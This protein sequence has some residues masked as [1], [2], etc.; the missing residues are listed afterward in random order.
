MQIDWS[1]F[2]WVLR[3]TLT[4]SLLSAFLGTA[5]GFLV[6][7][8]LLHIQNQ[9]IKKWVSA[10][11][12]AP[13]Y[14]PTLFFVLALLQLWNGF[15]KNIAGVIAVHI[16]M[17]FGF[18][19]LLLH[20]GLVNKAGPS[21]DLAIVLGAKKWS[22]IR[23]VLLPL[24]R[25]DLLVSFAS[26]FLFS[27][28]SFSVPML[29]GGQQVSSFEVMIYE[30][31]RYQADWSAA[32][33]I[34]LAQSVFLGA[35]FILILKPQREERKTVF[36]SLEW[37][38]LPYTWWLS[39]IPTG[40][41]IAGYLFSFTQSHFWLHWNEVWQLPWLQALLTSVQLGTITA[42]IALAIG[43]VASFLYF[44]TPL[45]HFVRFYLGPTSALVG[46]G[47]LVWGHRLNL[48]EIFQI[49]LAYLLVFQIYF[50]RTMIFPRIEELRKQHELAEILG[51]S[52]WSFFSRIT[53]P[54][55]I[56]A[57]TQATALMVIWSMGDFV[58]I[59]MI[60]K[61][62]TSLA[63]MIERLTNNY[64]LDQALLLS[65]LLG[66]F[67]FSLYHVIQKAGHVTH[68]KLNEKL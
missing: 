50:L 30:I 49:S 41:L 29:V 57:L 2:S 51:A 32:V 62:Q 43:S 10:A 56:P 53:L 36:H 21:T 9:K 52:S 65:A 55:T 7:L 22:Y 67:L 17:N 19:A 39:L 44:T 5:L 35:V 23:A 61:E 25:T 64:R 37:I 18:S 15:P 42:L 1:E 54:A 38:S 27:F 34:S 60:A 3:N 48:P 46:F 20:E 63:Q 66:V 68:Q 31:I 26:L 59:N 28:C 40:I 14:I 33:F 6:A 24:L 58:L 4:Q 16:L 12:F 13:F 45:T 11:C 47:V 8:G